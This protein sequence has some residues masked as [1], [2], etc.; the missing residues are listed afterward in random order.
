MRLLAPWQTLPAGQVFA[1]VGLAFVSYWTRAMRLYG[2]FRPPGMAAAPAHPAPT[3]LVHPC[4]AEVSEMQEQLSSRPDKR[5]T[6]GLYFKVMPQH[7]LL[8]NLLPMRTGEISFPLLIMRHFAVPMTRSVPA[9]FWFH[10]LDLH[11]LG[12]CALLAGLGLAWDITPSALEGAILLLA[13]ML[14]PLLL[15]WGQGH[16]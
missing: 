4:T 13:W 2:Y 1:A 10:L 16:W 6:F 15:F 9:L 5:G 11:T 7:N 12:A 3:A 14:L 8:N